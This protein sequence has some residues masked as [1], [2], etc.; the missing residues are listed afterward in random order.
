MSGS[1]PALGPLAS[2]PLFVQGAGETP[3][4]PG[5]GGGSRKHQPGGHIDGF[6][7]RVAGEDP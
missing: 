5:S 1:L 3:A 4:V 2:R 7:C 6:F